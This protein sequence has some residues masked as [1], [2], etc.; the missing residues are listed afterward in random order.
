MT[1]QFTSV[2]TFVANINKGTFGITMITKTEP[3]MNK[4]NNPFFGR[5]QKV[6]YMSNVGLGLSYENCVNNRLDRKGLENDYQAE[7]PKGK[8][9]INDFMLCS[10]KDTSV[11]YLRTT[12][13]KNT[14]TKSIFLLDGEIVD[15]ITLQKI[16]TFIP[17][18]TT[19]KK[20]EN[21]GLQD[22]EQ[23]IVRDFKLES[24][25]SLQQGQKVFTPTEIYAFAL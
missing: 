21:S 15:E 2:E 13:Y 23:V 6:T 20:Q 10:D 1:T 8:T 24:I 25:I 9:W 16:K 7:K 14:K 12:M 22:D 5:V 3:K 11:K 17:K 19:C 4:R 18:P